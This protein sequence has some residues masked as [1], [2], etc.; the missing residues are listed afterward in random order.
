MPL[1]DHTL[2]TE[3]PLCDN[4][5]QELWYHKDGYDIVTCQGCGFIYVRDYPSVEFLREYYSSTYSGT[6]YADEEGKYQPAGGVLRRLKYWAFTRWIRTHFPKDKPIQTLELG[7]GQGDFLRSVKNDDRFDARGLDY[8]DAPIAYACSLG[9]KAEKG[10]IQSKKYDDESFDLVV[11]LHVMEHVHDPNETF[12][13]IYRIL[14]PGGYA[15]V[16][17]PCVSHFKVKLAGENWKYLGPPG[18]LWYYS[19]KSLS[20]LMKKAGFSIKMAS[21]FYHRAHV[22]VFGKKN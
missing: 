4:G 12:S 19:P 13:E 16:V 1:D 22:R 21:C 15:F 17:C 18:H 8:A 7:C 6:I 9:L 5:G 2:L 10:D 14:R 20:G 11:A 3:C